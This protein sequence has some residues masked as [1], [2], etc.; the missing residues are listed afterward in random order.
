[1]RRVVKY[2]QLTRGCLR[3]RCLRVRPQA[4]RKTALR[5]VEGEP[6]DISAP[7][8]T[9]GAHRIAPNVPAARRRDHLEKAV[10][11][12]G[13]FNGRKWRESIKPT[14]ARFIRDVS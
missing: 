6:D 2:R 10:G 1:M 4:L 5:T 14:I 7:G 11:H 13:I 3:W 9:L 12:Y 8:Q